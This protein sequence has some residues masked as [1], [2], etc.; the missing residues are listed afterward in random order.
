MKLLQGMTFQCPVLMRR[1]LLSTVCNYA[2]AETLPST[3]SIFTI[4]K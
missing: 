2:N 3:K 1:K 4:K